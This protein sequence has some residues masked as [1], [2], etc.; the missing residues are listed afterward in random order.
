MARLQILELPT[1]HHGD[2]MVT[3]WILVI[4]QLPTDGGEAAAIRRDLASGDIPQLIGARAVLCFEETIE[5]PANGPTPGDEEIEVSDADFTEM[6]SAV[7]RALGIDMTQVGVKP[8][9]AGWLLTACRELENSEVARARL[10]DERAGQAADLE[11]LRAGEEPVTDERVAPSPAQWIWQWNR[12]KPEKRLSMAAQILDGMP[13]ANNCLMLDHEA[14]LTDLQ[15][16]VARLRAAKP[17][18]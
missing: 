17:D 15:A 3:P 6:A 18:A 7:H 5:I 13:R 2:D 12:A 9:I 4:D 11:R 14:R 16:E 1:E 8:D 10:R